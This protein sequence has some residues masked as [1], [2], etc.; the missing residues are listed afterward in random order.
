M[1]RPGIK[2]FLLI[3]AVLTVA[4]IVNITSPHQAQP[5]AGGLPVP[6]SAHGSGETGGVPGAVAALHPRPTRRTTR[7]IERELHE[8]GYVTGPVDGVADPVSRA[9]ILAYEYDHGLPLTAEPSERLLQALLLGDW[10]PPS[11]RGKEE[12]SREARELVLS[13]Q[14]S[15]QKLG[16]A[17]TS[18]D[19]IPGPETAEAIRQFEARHG[20]PRSGRVSGALAA[21]LGGLAQDASESPS[22]RTGSTK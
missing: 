15:L 3:H 17:I 13:V 5:V 8:K 2:T 9:A 11:A 19:G 7:A 16:Y 12:L 6:P 21:R 14:R 18:A 4:L 1:H 22:L 20:L 10:R